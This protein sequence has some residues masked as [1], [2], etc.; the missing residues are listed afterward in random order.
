[1]KSMSRSDTSFNQL[2]S[3]LEKDETLDKHSWN[4]Y[5]DRENNQDL[6]NEFMSNA[7]YIKEAK[8]KNYMYHE[9]LSLQDNDLS[10]SR[11]REII[12]DLANEYVKQRTDNNLVYGAVHNDTGNLHIHL[13]ISSNEV[14]ANKRFTLSKKELSQIQYNVQEYKNTKYT[15]LEKTH[16][17]NNSKDRS[18]SKQ[19][20]QEMK[21]KRGKKTQKE[22]VMENLKSMFEKS[23]SQKNLKSAMKQNGFEFTRGAKS[24]KVDG[25]SYRLKTLGLDKAYENT[26]NKFE[27]TKGREQKR[28]ESKNEKVKSRA[29][30]RKK[31][32]EN[33]REPLHKAK[34]NSKVNDSSR[35]R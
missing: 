2:L 22:L 6:E 14:N 24:V 18:K 9:V 27:R 33:T 29:T 20:E 21:H 35:S 25:R 5:A 8:G 4:M 34:Q 19:A 10:L 23:T 12:F 30:S 28:S 3:Y 26:L 1:M 16:H 32:K 7:E 15:E 11:Q 13:I 31:V 17:Y